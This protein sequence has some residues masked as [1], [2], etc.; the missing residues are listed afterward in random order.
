MNTLNKEWRLQTMPFN[1]DLNDAMLQQHHAAQ[2]IA[3]AGKYLIP[4][5]PDD[6]NTNMKYEPDGDLLVGNSMPNGMR[7][8]LHLTDLSI[9]ILD[10]NYNLKKEIALEGKSKQQVFDKLKQSLSDLGVDVTGFKNELHYEIPGHPLDHGAVFSVNDERYF[11][12]NTIYRHNAEIVLNEI[13][14]A[15]KQAEAVRIWPHHFDT[16][17]FIPVSRNEKGEISQS[18]GIGLAIPDSMVNEPYYYLS[19]WSDKPVENL[20]NL[21]PLDA[22]Q[23]MMPDWNGAILKLS[24]I[25]K[26]DTTEKQYQLVESF[27][28]T[29][30]DEL[31]N[32]LKY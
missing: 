11:T 2:F 30:I 19:F 12:E 17:S 15:H 5:Q 28:K 7:V 14:N 20:N 21:P 13:A 29:G 22:G 18:I 23:W 16:G 26:E 27:F 9:N 25:A 10:K 4:Q 1:E 8:A 3:L 24:E 32:L 6:S 31:V